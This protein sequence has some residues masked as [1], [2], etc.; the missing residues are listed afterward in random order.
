MKELEYIKIKN[1]FVAIILEQLLTIKKELLHLKRICNFF[2]TEDECPYADIYIY[3]NKRID[4]YL[5]QI[6]D[7]V[8]KLEKI[9][10]HHM[11][12]EF[13]IYI[14]RIQKNIGNILEG[15][16]LINNSIRQHNEESFNPYMPKAHHGRRYSSK[17]ISTFIRNYMKEVLEKYAGDKEIKALIVWTFRHGF[18]AEK[19]LNPKVIETAHYYYDLPYFI[20]N[21][22]HE[23]NHI[24]FSLDNTSSEFDSYKNLDREYKNAIENNIKEFGL[25]INDEFPEEFI[26]DLFAYDLL[27]VSYIY[28]C[29]YSIAY[30]GMDY[31]FTSNKTKIISL[32]NFNKLKSKG[33][34]EFKDKASHVFEINLRL[35]LLIMYAL[36]DKNLDSKI[37][38]EINELDKFLRLLFFPN[39]ADD[40]SLAVKYSQ[41]SELLE[42]NFNDLSEAMNKSLTVFRTF[43][44]NHKQIIFDGNIKYKQIFNDIWAEKLD[45]NNVI[46]HRN[47]LRERILKE[48]FIE[49]KYKNFDYDAYELTFF[50]FRDHRELKEIAIDNYFIKFTG[51]GLSQNMTKDYTQYE[52]YG[53]YDNFAIRKKKKEIEVEKVQ[54]FLKDVKGYTS[55]YYTY[56]MAMIKLYDNTLNLSNAFGFGAI[57]QIQLENQ[58]IETIKKGFDELLKILQLD[59]DCQYSIYKILGPNDYIVDLKYASMVTIFKLKKKLAKNFTFRRTLT[60]IYKLDKSK[61]GANEISM[62]HEISNI[63]LKG[64]I[65]IEDIKF[66]KIDKESC[67]EDYCH[68]IKYITGAQDIQIVWKV[69]V[70]INLIV[71]KLGDFISDIQSNYEFKL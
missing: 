69:D 33:E 13:M 4:I 51:F 47:S 45:K 24:L 39:N 40:K 1:N 27:G 18:K 26:S 65:N 55:N 2:T 67:L 12:Y 29:F 11:A 10:T 50:K 6:D 38:K 57:L 48:I 9:S 61:L 23:L 71:S 14:D 59:I 44:I 56:K 7:I 32:A 63:R 66:L 46:F 21:I 36:G 58:N 53:I 62:F 68:K 15:V 35:R 25:K 34:N 49:E 3:N 22:F 60:T 54:D 70:D 5:K 20:P 8:Q 41:V 37:K 43:F 28:S 42:N 19:N 16:K 31:L 17:A 30:S 64:N 52:C